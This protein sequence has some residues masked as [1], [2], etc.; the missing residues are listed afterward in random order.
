[1]EL[2]EIRLNRN[3]TQL[4]LSEL[5]GCDR[6]TIVKIERGENKPSIKLAKTIADVLGFDWTLFFEDIQSNKGA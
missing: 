1:M 2:K 4:Q 3:L 5:C 6:T